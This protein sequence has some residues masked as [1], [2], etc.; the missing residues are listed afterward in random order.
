MM[1][2]HRTKAPTLVH[3]RLS[4]AAREIDHEFEVDRVRFVFA[5]KDTGFPNYIRSWHLD[6]IDGNGK[7]EGVWG[8]NELHGEGINSM[9]DRAMR[10]AVRSAQT[11]ASGD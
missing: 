8:A 7:R 3:M 5:V 9:F 11:R 4:E 1:P 10:F 6:R 2:Q